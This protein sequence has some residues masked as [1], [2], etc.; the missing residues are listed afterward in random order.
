MYRYPGRLEETD[1]VEEGREDDSRDEVV[2]FVLLGIH[3][4]LLLVGCRGQRVR[5]DE[6]GLGQ[7]IFFWF[8]GDGGN[9]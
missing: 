8:V 7:W 9:K 5:S 6:G 2:V 4:A 1:C 3:R